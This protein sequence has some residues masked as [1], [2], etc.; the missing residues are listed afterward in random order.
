MRNRCIDNLIDCPPF[1]IMTL[2]NVWDVQ[3][4][5][6]SVIFQGIIYNQ[7]RVSATSRLSSLLFVELARLLIS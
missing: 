4:P 3:R 6:K 5:V 1:D 2:D 7:K